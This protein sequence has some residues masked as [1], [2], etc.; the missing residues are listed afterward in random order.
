MEEN[1]LIRYL[2]GMK[3][4]LVIDFFTGRILEEKIDFEQLEG[5]WA[6]ARSLLRA[7]SGKSCQALEDHQS[8]LLRL[9]RTSIEELYA[10]GTVHRTTWRDAAVERM[11]AGP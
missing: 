3:E 5:S 8:V 4:R 2:D 9:F 7:D 6:E 11:E 10:V 1:D